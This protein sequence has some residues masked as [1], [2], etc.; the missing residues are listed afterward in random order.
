MSVLGVERTC[1]QRPSQEPAAGGHWQ[2]R[3]CGDLGAGSSPK[4]E[5]CRASRLG[6][7]LRAQ[8]REQVMGRRE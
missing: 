8:K 3:A 4:W 2:G 5:G 7:Q 6:S 1:P